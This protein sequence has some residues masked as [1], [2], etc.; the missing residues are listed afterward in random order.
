M[1]SLVCALLT[2]EALSLVVQLRPTFPYI[3][4]SWL[5]AAPQETELANL[6]S[7]THTGLYIALTLILSLAALTSAFPTKRPAYRLLFAILFSGCASRALYGWNFETPLTDE[8]VSS[9]WNS[10]NLISIAFGFVGTFAALQISRPRTSQAAV[11]L[12]VLTSLIPMVSLVVVYLVEGL[13]G[14]QQCV[15]GVVWS[16]MACHGALGLTVRVSELMRD[17]EVSN[18]S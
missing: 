17:V 12:F 11:I 1:L 8:G 9:F 3:Q 14:L 7:Q 6:A 16:A 15:P 4:L 2:S 18:V 10:P 13:V 5:Q